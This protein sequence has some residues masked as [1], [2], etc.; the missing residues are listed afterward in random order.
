MLNIT[1]LGL[2]IT[3]VGKKDVYYYTF[4]EL[5]LQ[6]WGQLLHFWG[7]MT[8]LGKSSQL[9]QIWGISKHL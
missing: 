9:L 1:H 6:I 4:G 8:D 5:L 3:K 7:T 2:T